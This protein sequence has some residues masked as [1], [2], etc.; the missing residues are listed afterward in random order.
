M[1]GFI[2]DARNP[3]LSFISGSASATSRW[4]IRLRP[5]HL[6]PTHRDSRAGMGGGPRRRRRDARNQRDR[7]HRRRSASTCYLRRRQ[8]DDGIERRWEW[9]GVGIERRPNRIKWS[10]F[11]PLSPPHSLTLKGCYKDGSAGARGLTDADACPLTASASPTIA[12]LPLHDRIKA[13][14]HASSRT[15]ARKTSITATYDDSATHRATHRCRCRRSVI[16]S[17]HTRAPV[18]AGGR[19]EAKRSRQIRSAL[20]ESS[21]RATTAPAAV[22]NVAAAVVGKR[23]WRS[24][25][26]SVRMPSPRAELAATVTAASAARTC[27]HAPRPSIVRAFLAR[28]PTTYTAINKRPRR[29]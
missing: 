10:N 1:H 17:A 23:S 19:P 9:V 15:T 5:R 24:C 21:F 7:M 4:F 25:V 14:R 6:W 27:A 26:S 11:L 3:M 22:K 18:R 12:A 29:L 2:T 8:R 13:T 28:L 16:V 20:S